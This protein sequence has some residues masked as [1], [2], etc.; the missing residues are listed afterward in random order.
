MKNISFVP[1]YAV[2]I[3]IVETYSMITD[4]PTTPQQWYP[5]KNKEYWLY[6]YCVAST[7]R[8]VIETS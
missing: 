2:A 8:D 4:S 3:G 7:T 6:Y 1:R 5:G